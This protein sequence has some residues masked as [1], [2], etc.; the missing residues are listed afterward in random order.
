MRAGQSS[1]VSYQRTAVTGWSRR[2]GADVGQGVWHD[3]PSRGG[4]PRSPRAR[5]LGAEDHGADFIIGSAVVVKIFDPLSRIGM[6][7]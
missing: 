3:P 7:K 6:A 1:S 2:Y 4:R 5:I